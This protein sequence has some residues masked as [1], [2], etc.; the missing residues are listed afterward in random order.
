MHRSSP[1]QSSN[2]N[3][4]WS[5]SS[6]IKSITSLS[7]FRFFIATPPLKIRFKTIY[8]SAWAPRHAGDRVVQIRAKIMRII[9]SRLSC[10]IEQLFI[11]LDRLRNFAAK[12]EW[13]CSQLH[14]EIL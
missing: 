7:Q 13:Q 4:Q 14:A 2:Q 5:F 1:R 11:F 9:A 3:G 6:S 10:R 8:Q 12:P